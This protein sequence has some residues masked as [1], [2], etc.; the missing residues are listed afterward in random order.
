[1]S[2]EL[3]FIITGDHYELKELGDMWG[4]REDFK[5][6]INLLGE[7]E[8]NTELEYLEITIN[9]IPK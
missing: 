3:N 7:E 4:D 2:K 6:K 5:L 9:R 8:F 1:M